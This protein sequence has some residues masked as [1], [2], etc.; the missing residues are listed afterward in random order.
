MIGN[1]VC[2]HHACEYTASLQSGSDSLDLGSASTERHTVR[3]VVTRNNGLWILSQK[4]LRLHKWQPSSQHEAIGGDF[5][6]DA[7]THIGD[8]SRLTGTGAA[9]RIPACHLAYRV[10]KDVVRYNTCVPQCSSEA[11]LHQSDAQTAPLS[12]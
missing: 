12:A 3:R 6:T 1:P 11:N 5:I 4:L 2:W 7:A 10:T 8:A 9:V